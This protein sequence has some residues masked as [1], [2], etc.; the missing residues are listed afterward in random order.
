VIVDARNVIR[1]RWPNFDEERFLEL[2]RSWADEEGARLVAVFDGR[3]PS[4]GVGTQELDERTTVV[5]TGAESADDWIATHAAEMARDEN[6][7]WLVS[8]DRELGERVAAYVERM[9]GGG[10][11]ATALEALD[12]TRAS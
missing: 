9:I 4:A 5:G 11:L 3:A 7:L 2:A 6:A 8:S 1:S 10:S 12:S